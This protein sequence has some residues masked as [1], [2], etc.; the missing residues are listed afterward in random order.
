MV[1]SPLDKNSRGDRTQ[2][3][4]RKKN[5]D[6]R[7]ASTTVCFTFCGSFVNGAAWYTHLIIM[8][9]HAH[10]YLIFLV[11]RER[12]MEKEMEKVMIFLPRSLR[13]ICEID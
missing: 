9:A 8:F 7:M 4:K 1:S 10:D 13:K 12:K 3:R 2:R 6:A 5:P 11:D